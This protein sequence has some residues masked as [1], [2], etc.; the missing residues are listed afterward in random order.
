[1]TEFNKELA[2]DGIQQNFAKFSRV[3]YGTKIIEDETEKRA[4]MKKLRIYT[5]LDISI[6]LLLTFWITRPFFGT[7]DVFIEPGK[8]VGEEFIQ[9]VEILSPFLA[10]SL[11]F[12]AISLVLMRRGRINVFVWLATSVVD[13]GLLVIGVWN[14]YIWLFHGVKCTWG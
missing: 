12:D 6:A 1:V 3:P 2:V 9:L 11:I 14:I 5:A 8:T 10:A 13:L 7:C 4:L